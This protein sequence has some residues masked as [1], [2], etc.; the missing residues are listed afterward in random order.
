MVGTA[1]GLVFAGSKWIALGRMG[2]VAGSDQKSLRTMLF[3][4]TRQ[5]GT[6]APGVGH[7]AVACSSWR[8]AADA[9]AIDKHQGDGQRRRRPEGPEPPDEAKVVRGG[10]RGRSCL[11]TVPGAS[12]LATCEGGSPGAPEL[13]SRLPM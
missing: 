9:L 11:R 5:K 6:V 4:G 2:G 3:H 10:A 1:Q 12:A 13:K 7:G 8:S